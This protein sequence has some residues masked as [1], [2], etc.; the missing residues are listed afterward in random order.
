M[1]NANT[2]ALYEVQYFYY[3][4]CFGRHRVLAENSPNPLQNDWDEALEAAV[5]MEFQEW[6]MDLQASSRN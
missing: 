6:W 2:E 5:R 1:L 4:I 3:F